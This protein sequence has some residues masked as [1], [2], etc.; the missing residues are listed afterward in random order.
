MMHA[1]TSEGNIVYEMNGTKQKGKQEQME[2]KTSVGCS[3][4]G[5]AEDAGPH[6]PSTRAE[7][8]E[9]DRDPLLGEQRRAL[10]R[11]HRACNATTDPRSASTDKHHQYED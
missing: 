6:A 11:V 2:R 10:L 4:H 7:S 9:P 1:M 5:M 8:R 3:G